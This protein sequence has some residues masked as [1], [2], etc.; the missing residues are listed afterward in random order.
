[1]EG[2]TKKVCK[3]IILY[4]LLIALAILWIVPMFTLLATAVKS[5]E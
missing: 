2:K 3:K 4:M 1:M 5:K